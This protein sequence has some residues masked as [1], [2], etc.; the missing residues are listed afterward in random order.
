MPGGTGAAH[1]WR[2]AT[3]DDQISGPRTADTL[4]VDKCSG[5]PLRASGRRPKAPGE[6]SILIPNPSHVS[7]FYSESF[8]AFICPVF[9]GHFLP[10]GPQFTPLPTHSSVPHPGLSFANFLIFSPISVFLLHFLGDILNFI[11]LPFYDLIKNS[12]IF[13]LI[14]KS[15]FWSSG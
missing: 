13:N 9:W 5:R 14:S 1:T 4:W 3:Q 7:S 10:L 15:S 12:A 6:M 2:R 8:R 11:F